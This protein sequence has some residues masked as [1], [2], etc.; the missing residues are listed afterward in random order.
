MA[1]DLRNPE[2]NAVTKITENAV[3]LVEVSIF[4]IFSTYSSL[5]EL[6]ATHFP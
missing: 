4:F 1:P 3:F 2:K 6:L 5:I